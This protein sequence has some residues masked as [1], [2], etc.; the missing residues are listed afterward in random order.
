M[1]R[2]NLIITGLVILVLGV[3]VFAG[4]YVRKEKNNDDKK[5]E[6]IQ[7]ENTSGLANPASVFC[8]SRGG[9]LEIRT[10]SDGGQT[11]ACKFDDG[12][13]CEEW[14]FYRGECKKG[15]SVTV[16]DE[17]EGWNTYTNEKY[18]YRFKY[19]STATVSEAEKNWFSLSPDEAVA[20]LTFEDLYEEYTGK[21]CVTVRHDLGYVNISAPINVE[22]GLVN[23]GRTSR[24]YEGPDIT[25]NLNI[26]GR[27]YTAT[28]FEEQGPGETLMYHNEMLVVSLE[29]KTRIEFGSWSDEEK[30]YQD[31]LAI[32][33]DLIKIVESFEEFN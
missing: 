19:P 24:A 31:Y 2:K 28:G 12:S 27:A 6:V 17:Y 18:G 23:C 5:E 13:E 14:A 1:S 11:G 4:Y 33:D 30:T 21:V 8:E 32:K 25:Q 26:G 29:D 16:A 7:K 10:A 9:E 3:G 22:K 15:D 20:G